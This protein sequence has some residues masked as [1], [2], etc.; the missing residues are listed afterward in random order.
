MRTRLLITLAAAVLLVT[1]IWVV[2]DRLAPEGSGVADA[3]V[4]VVHPLGFLN[5]DPAV[6]F[7]GDEECAV[8][9]PD[10][11]ESYQHTGMSRSFYRPSAGNVIEDYQTHNRVHDL[12]NDLHYEMRTEGGRFYQVEYRLDEAGRRSHELRR[13]VD[14]VIGSGRQ[15]RTYITEVNGL[16]FELP[17]TWYV[18]E[19]IWD[20]SPGYKQRNLRFSRPIVPECM[21]C[22]NSYT[23]RIEYS[24]NG[25]RN[26]PSGIG[27]ER[28]HGPG[29]LHAKMR[30]ERRG[31]DQRLGEKD[32][33]IVNPDRLPLREQMDVCLQ[34]HLVGKK[35]VQ[36]EG[37]TTASF[38]P[39]MKLTE[40]KST[41]VPA[42]DSPDDFDIASHGQRSSLS[43]CY[44]RS[45]GEMTCSYCHDP[46]QPAKA[47][48]RDHYIG[49]CISCHAI[50]TL[51]T[52]RPKADH[53]Q[54]AD[55]IACHMRQGGTADVLH[56]NFTDHWIRKTISA[57][58]PHPAPRGKIFQLRSFFKESDP[59]ADIRKGIAYLLY[60]EG[61]HAAPEYLD[62]ALELLGKGVAAK[63]GHINGLYHLGKAYLHSGRLRQ[64]AE[65][66]QTVVS[67]APDHLAAYYSKGLVHEKLGELQAAR[68][69]YERCL[70]LYPGD[71]RVL[72][73]LGNIESEVGNSE[74]AIYYY[75]RA[76][77]AEPTYAISYANLG[78]LNYLQFQDVEGAKAMLS[79][80]LKLD[81]DFAVA[82]NNI[83]SMQ[84]AEGKVEAALRNF[85]RV[86][87][88]D[89]ANVPAHGNMATIYLHRNDYVR[90]KRY[91]Q[92]LLKIAPQDP[93]AEEML[94]WVEEQMQEER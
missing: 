84:L 36:R 55:C 92:A 37:M 51:S 27:C 71:A 38:R 43:T 82:L 90:A 24:E 64:A 19:G 3:R 28:C 39:G 49:A 85:S 15:T 11:Y 13:E 30:Y 54:G 32:I 7:V 57:R 67:L 69:A 6:K 25:F 44:I 87:E 53:R 1:A 46:H 23:D 14:W 72:N 17:V 60:Y 4:A 76:I 48:G 2:Q 88:I 65:I 61:N 10:I 29:G 80:A 21:N 91:L 63:A 58:Q 77:R 20:L 35:T 8:C 74:K 86:L 56:V 33:T 41:Y 93:A 78:R 50:K 47:Q 40:W 12:R 81:P 45:G 66:F 70:T 16:F 89:P 52:G 68:V 94:Q 9:H 79:K 42:T 59:A 83:G 31:K 34:C 5:L 62:R 73:N 26:V 75:E 18:D 22:H